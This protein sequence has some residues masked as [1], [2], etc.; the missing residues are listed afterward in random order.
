MAWT[1]RHG[2]VR[3]LFLHSCTCVHSRMLTHEEGRQYQRT[4]WGS[5][6]PPST[7]CV[8]GFRLRL[9]HHALQQALLGFLF[10]N[11]ASS[12]WRLRT[13]LR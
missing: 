3:S 4:T 7:V 13:V 1:N 6:F 12:D 10:F 9:P 8:P 2:C 5:C 11:L